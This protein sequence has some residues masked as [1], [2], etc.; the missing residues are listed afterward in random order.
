MICDDT[1]SPG[2]AFLLFHEIGPEAHL[3]T[4]AGIIELLFSRGFLVREGKKIHATAAGRGLIQSLPLT[5]TTPDMTAHWE[6]LL[7]AISARETSYE[8]FMLPLQKALGELI[9]QSQ[10]TLPQGLSDI[11]AKRP[12]FRRRAKRSPVTRRPGTPGAA[13]PRTRRARSA[14]KAPA[15]G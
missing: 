1:I 11:P 2:Y 14:G 4:R 6:T 12:S 7:S 9:M 15:K 10:A 13:P 8:A 3:S 5:A